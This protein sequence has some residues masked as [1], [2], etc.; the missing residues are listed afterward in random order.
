MA[1]GSPEYH[2]DWMG[3]RLGDRPGAAVLAFETFEVTNGKYMPT[4]VAI[5]GG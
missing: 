3:Y 2:M 5:F 4:Y 1:G